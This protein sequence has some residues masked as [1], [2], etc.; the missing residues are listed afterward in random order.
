MKNH[1][2]PLFIIGYPRSGTTWTMWLLSQH[3]EVVTSF[4]GGLFLSM[5]H[6][7]K[8]R[9]TP[10]K[11][12][13]F[14]LPSLLPDETSDESQDNRQV[15]FAN[16]LPPNFF[17][18]QIEEITYEYF[19]LIASQGI[20]PKFVVENT[21]ENMELMSWILEIVPEAY[22]LHVVRDPRSVWL[23]VRRAFQSWKRLN[24][25]NTFPPT[26]P[27][28]MR[29]WSEY[30]VLGS[31]IQKKSNHYTEIKYESLHENGIAELER[32]FHWLDLPTNEL[33]C[34]RILEN[35]TIDKVKEAI[36]SPKGFFGKGKPYSW[37]KVLS[38]SEIRQ[39]EFLADEL[40]DKY[41]YKRHFSPQARQPWQLWINDNT[42]LLSDLLRRKLN[43]W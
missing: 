12:G 28:N 6:L 19:N 5:K 7:E 10:G 37:K 21:P 20:N 18:K 9:K 35:S 8:W 30:M 16:V 26:L 36:P 40:L 4:H 43:S 32:L 13:K 22:V 1:F 34:E 3:P 31:D 38:N 27:K 24:R 17:Q 14:I 11:F 2:K 23:S 29:L 42:S 25:P 41:Q 39:I 15:K 33:Q